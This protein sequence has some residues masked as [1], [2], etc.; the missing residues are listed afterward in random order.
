MPPS[1]PP[2]L[3]DYCVVR[4]AVTWNDLTIIWCGKAE[5]I[6]EVYCHEDGK[7]CRKTTRGDRPLYLYG[8]SVTVHG[9]T[10][11][12][13]FG[14]T[15]DENNVFNDIFA[16]DLNSWTWAKLNPR[17]TP[18]SVC[19]GFRPWV[20]NA[21]VY[22]FGGVILFNYH[23]TFSNQFFCYNISANCW[24]WPSPSGIIPSPRSGHTTFLCGNTAI[25][26]G[27]L[28][29]GSDGDYLPLNDL[30]TL[31]MAGMTWTQ[32]HPSLTGV[33]AEELPETRAGHSMTLISTEVAV[34]FGGMTSPLHSNRDCWILNT[35]RVLRGEF[36]RP[37]SLWRHC[38][39]HESQGAALTN[40]S[41][42]VE[43]ISK[44]LWIIGGNV[45][46]RPCQNNVEILSIT[47]NSGTPLKLLAMESVLK[48]FHPD[49]PM[50]EA[51]ELPKTLQIELKN[52]AGN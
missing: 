23:M 45:G 40:H 27:G 5:S 33:A 17:G 48:Y 34:L 30:Y 11:Y 36:E 47:L 4:V 50:L 12:L 38:Q 21:K 35:G 16:L 2:E 15:K 41:A 29:N 14:Q 6:G 1:L 3:K 19:R 24:E 43:P 49:H 25:L 18:P 7:W 26:F 9:D 22:G 44:R 52:R 46:L 28:T 8:S 39:E 20:Y 51:T 37:S 42:V 31:D 10:L 32:V 13:M